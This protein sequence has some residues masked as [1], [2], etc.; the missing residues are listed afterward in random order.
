MTLTSVLLEVVTINRNSF[1]TDEE[2]R[3]SIIWFLVSY[4]ITSTLVVIRLFT[5]GITNYILNIIILISLIALSFSIY[6]VLMAFCYY[7]FYPDMMGCT[8]EYDYKY[9]PMR[10]SQ[11]FLG[12]IVYVVIRIF[13]KSSEGSEIFLILSIVNIL[14]FLE[15][16]KDSSRYRFA[17]W[18]TILI[19]A[20]VLSFMF[21]DFKIIFIG[22][23]L[24]LSYKS[25]K[26]RIKF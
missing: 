23:V 13:N 8:S 7:D 15:L 1:Y 22:L 18:I 14:F 12:I 24:C 3:E 4:I 21:T 9:E 16:S 20:L 6:D 26:N 17:F 5:S 25:I 19:I 10:L 2:T 11:L